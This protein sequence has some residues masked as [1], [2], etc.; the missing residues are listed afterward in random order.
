MKEDFNHFWS[1]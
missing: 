1:K